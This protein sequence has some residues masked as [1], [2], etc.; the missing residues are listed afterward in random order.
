MSHYTNRHFD[1]IRPLMQQNEKL[2]ES[3]FQNAL[4]LAQTILSMHSNEG[5][6][7]QM[8]QVFNKQFEQIDKICDRELAHEV[9]LGPP[10]DRPVEKLM[11]KTLKSR[12][13][14]PIKLGQTRE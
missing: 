8:H 13:F 10:E 4:S 6:P 7:M 11:F 12:N 5:A 9:T 14:K 2:N 3:N 1:D